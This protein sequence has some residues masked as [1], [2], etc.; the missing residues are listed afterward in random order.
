MPRQLPQLPPRLKT[1]GD[2]LHAARLRLNLTQREAAQSLGISSGE[3]SHAET[4]YGAVSMTRLKQLSE[5]YRLSPGERSE[6][7]KA[8]SKD[9]YVRVTI[10]HLPAADK[11]SILE[12]IYASS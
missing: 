7:L 4:G 5:L 11:L 3:I 2:Y 12:T 9:N 8:A 6:L 10:D 1:V